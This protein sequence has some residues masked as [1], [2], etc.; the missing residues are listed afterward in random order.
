MN[1]LNT[2]FKSIGFECLLK[3][4]EQIVPRF[5]LEF[6]SQ[7]D[8]DYNS[9]GDFVVYFV[10]QNK[11]FSFN[12]KEFGHILGIPFEGHCS[13]SDKWSLDYL[14][15][16]TPTKGR[17]QTTPPSL[18]VIK[19]L[20]QTHRQGHITRVHNKK[21][22]DVDENKI[23]NRKF[24]N[25]MIGS[26]SFVRMYYVYE[27]S[28]DLYI[29]CD[30]VMHPLT[31]YYEPMTQSDHG[32]KTCHQSNPSSSSNVLDHSSSCHHVD[33]NDDAN[34]EESSQSNTPSPSQLINSLLNIV[35]M[36]FENP[37]H[38]NQTIHTYQTKI[39][40]HQ[41]QYRHEHRKGLRS[42][43]RALKNAMRGSK[44]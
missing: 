1:Y 27:L 22:I 44:K 36:V 18:S 11:S 37:P 13:Y 25:H 34:D 7:L 14:E 19:T 17:Y 41:N 9:K 15:I 3:I 33:E 38:K 35:S 42:I 30:S 10:I 28:D 21:P 40:N 29:L 2:K 32:T 43:R 4:K 12:L 39:L 31:P 23:L 24:Q 16:S 8:F 6:Y 20:I 26:R 5:V